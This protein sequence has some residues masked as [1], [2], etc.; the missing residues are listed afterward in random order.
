M[1]AIKHLLLE[2]YDHIVDI[3]DDE[4]IVRIA[5]GRGHNEL[6]KILESIPAFEVRL[7]LKPSISLSL[8]QKKKNVQHFQ[9]NR[10]KLHRS[11]RTGNIDEVK[12]LIE[13]PDGHEY[14]QAKNYYGTYFS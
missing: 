14:A 13:L 2:G 9:I 7:H 10:E 11:I 12:R 3:H 4:S 6:G 8:A 1:D 5:Y